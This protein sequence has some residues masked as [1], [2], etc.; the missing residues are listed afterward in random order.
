MAYIEFSLE[1]VVPTFQL[2]KI[3]TTALFSNVELVPPS[4]HLTTALAKKAALATA[5]GTEKARS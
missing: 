4:D 3:D 2:E 5:I 1:S